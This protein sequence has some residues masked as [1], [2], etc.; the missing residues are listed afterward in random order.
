MVGSSKLRQD[1]VEQLKLPCNSVQLR[2][3]AQGRGMKGVCTYV[4][5][6]M[7]ACMCVCVR[8]CVRVCVCVCIY[9]HTRYTQWGSVQGVLN[10]IA[11]GGE[12]IQLLIDT[13]HNRADSS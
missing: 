4:N 5:V 3:A 7:H 9:I 13:S 8:A 2:T 10:R 12:K 6:C 11:A 1:A